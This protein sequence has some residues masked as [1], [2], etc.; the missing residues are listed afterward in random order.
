MREITPKKKFI[1]EI[2]GGPS[3]CLLRRKRPDETTVHREAQRGTV[4]HPQ[5]RYISATTK[6]YR[7][8][9]GVPYN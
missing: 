3:V 9:Q 2:Q 6:E 1:M 5:S 8:S 7:D 4:V